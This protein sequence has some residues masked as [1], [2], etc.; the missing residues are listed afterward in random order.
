MPQGKETMDPTGPKEPKADLKRPI[1]M[2]D[3]GATQNP[4]KRP[5]VNI[6]T[7]QLTPLVGS[8]DC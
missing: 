3:A 2:S 1:S 7:S 6:I 8:I 5:K 4:Q